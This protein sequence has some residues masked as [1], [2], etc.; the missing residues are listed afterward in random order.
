MLEPKKQILQAFLE[1]LGWAFVEI[2]VQ[3][4][5]K[6]LIWWRRWVTAALILVL[7]CPG[8]QGPGPGL[9]V[10]VVRTWP[11]GSG[12]L[13]LVFRFWSFGSDPLILVLRTWSFGS[14]RL[15]PAWLQH[16]GCCCRSVM[17]QQQQL[18]GAASQTS[19]SHSEP[20]NR[21]MDLDLDL[22]RWSSSVLYSA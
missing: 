15:L 6:L 4:K 17:S 9:S 2:T 20:L 5:G 10:L 14:A 22:G 18:T 3:S 13:V 1:L 19:S 8:K 7:V 11:F 12:P 21:W 16:Q